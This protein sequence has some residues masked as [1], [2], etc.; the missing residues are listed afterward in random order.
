MSYNQD[1]SKA[2][3]SQTWQNQGY[4]QEMSLVERIERAIILSA[5]IIT[6]IGEGIQIKD[7][8]EQPQ[9]KSLGVASTQMQ[10]R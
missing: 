4:R 1:N 3:K 10:S 8:I 7:R 6:M 5:A 9:Q 2:S